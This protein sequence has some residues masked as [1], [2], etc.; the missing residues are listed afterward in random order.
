M[1]EVVLDASAVL[2]Y[3]YGEP[4]ADVV[5]PALDRAII[6]SVNL[7]EVVAR[8]AESSG[9]HDQIHY[10]LSRLDLQAVPFDEDQAYIAGMLRPATRPFGLSLGDRAC[11]A[12]AQRD[13]LP[14][15]TSDQNWSRV[16]VDIDIQ[17]IR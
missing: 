16:A 10:D 14:A 13:D 3:I 17:L 7:S 2:A 9:E 6:S 4:G 1:D 15:L 11:L 12:L 8:L 5:A